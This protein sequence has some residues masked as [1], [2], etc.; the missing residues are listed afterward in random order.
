MSN[1]KNPDNDT[2]PSNNEGEEVPLT[3]DGRIP[4]WYTARMMAKE[5]PVDG[6]PDFW[7][8]WKDEMKEGC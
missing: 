3:A 5:Y 6:D 1:T 8:R 2:S 7:D 4:F